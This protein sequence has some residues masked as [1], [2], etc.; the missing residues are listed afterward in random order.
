MAIPMVCYI[1][2]SNQSN[3]TNILSAVSILMTWCCCTCI[4][5]PNCT[6]NMQ[7]RMSIFCV[8]SSFTVE[9]WKIF[10]PSAWPWVEGGCRY[11]LNKRCCCGWNWVIYVIH[12][13]NSI[14]LW[15]TFGFQ[16][17]PKIKS[18]HSHS[19][20]QKSSDFAHDNVAYFVIICTGRFARG[21]AWK[22]VTAVSFFRCPTVSLVHLRSPWLP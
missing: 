12:N 6:K 9:Q 20:F 22:K 11:G 18:Y 5:F 17:L 3:T 13:C 15:Y 4:I 16:N 14:N 8:D 7:L 21:H 19:E 10:F 2:E 1:S